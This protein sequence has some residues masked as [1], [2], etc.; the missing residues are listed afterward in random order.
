MG[1]LG[2]GGKTCLALNQEQGPRMAL[3]YLGFEPNR[4]LTEL[5]CCE[6][7]SGEGNILFWLGE[8]GGHAYL[9]QLLK[10]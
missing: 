10:T 8:T 4:A 2:S 3:N 9:M 6:K 5:G 7:S 1:I